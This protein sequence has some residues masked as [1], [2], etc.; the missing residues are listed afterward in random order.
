MQWIG[1]DT[2]SVHT[3]TLQRQNLQH[4]SHCWCN[5]LRSDNIKSYL[6]IQGYFFLFFLFGP[7]YTPSSIFTHT[8]YDYFPLTGSL[9]VRLANS[10]DEC[11]GRV[12]VRQ[13]DV[14][15]TVCD[16]DWTLSK[17]QVVCD[18]LQCGTA[19]E[20]PGGAHFGQGSGV[21]VEASD[22]CF[23][24]MTNLKECSLKG[25]RSSSCGHDH[26]AGALCAGRVRNS[27]KSR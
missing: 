22:S 5:L 2:G 3:Q 4:H 9:E 8:Q 6:D 21:V 12:E 11:S 26:D 25:F 15:H 16:Q 27:A 14:W 19:Y 17:A 23:K 1:V 10:K 18:N 20:A 7:P 13:G 24:N